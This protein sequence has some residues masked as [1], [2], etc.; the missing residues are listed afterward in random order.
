MPCFHL[1]V[2]VA[3]RMYVM[4]FEKFYL[5]LHEEQSLTEVVCCLKDRGCLDPLGAFKTMTRSRSD[6]PGRSR[7]QNI[8]CMKIKFSFPDSNE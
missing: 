4:I 5:V 2:T 1:T 7:V 6:V 3:L 8:Y